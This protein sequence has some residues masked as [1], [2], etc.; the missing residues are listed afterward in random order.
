MKYP[1]I[2]SLRF[3]V[4]RNLHPLILKVTSL[5]VYIS[6]FSR[7]WINRVWLPFC[8]RSARQGKC[9]LPCPR[10]RP[11]LWFRGTG[12]AVPSRVISLILHSKTTINRLNLMMWRLTFSRISY[13]IPFF[14]FPVASRLV[15]VLHLRCLQSW[16]LFQ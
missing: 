10:S 11:R 14:Y 3:P 8:S 9:A 6:T 4:S 15:Q 5:P 16:V 1:L 13:L 2:V 7:V 12:S